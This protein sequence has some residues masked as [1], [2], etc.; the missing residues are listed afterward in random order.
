MLFS[1]KKVATWKKNAQIWVIFID[2]DFHRSFRN[3]GGPGVHYLFSGGKFVVK[4]ALFMIVT[5]WHR[6]RAEKMFFSR[7]KVASWNKNVQIWVILI[8]LDFQRSF[9]NAGG[10]GFH[11]L[12]SVG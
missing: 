9:R 4:Q 5:V 6:F 3:T 1:P 8:D 11:Y 12:L 2:L 7:K 10:A